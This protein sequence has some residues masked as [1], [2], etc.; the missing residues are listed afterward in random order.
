[1]AESTKSEEEGR[2]WGRM[3]DRWLLCA[4]LVE[5]EHAVL[6][7]PA[8]QPGPAPGEVYVIG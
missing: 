3:A 4:R 7:R 8:P 2:V 5:E 6:K 1:M